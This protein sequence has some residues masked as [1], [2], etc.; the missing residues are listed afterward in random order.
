MEN[1]LIAVIVISIVQL[2]TVVIICHYMHKNTI[3][4]AAFKRASSVEEAAALLRMATEKPEENED[5]QA[6]SLDFETLP[7]DIDTEF[8]RSQL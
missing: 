2:I 4:I 8:L 5:E 1:I 7:T 3:S 6:K